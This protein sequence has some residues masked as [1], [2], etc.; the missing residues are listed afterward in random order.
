MATARAWSNAHASASRSTA[1]ARVERR[2]GCVVIRASGGD[3]KEGVSYDVPYDVVNGGSEDGYELRVYGAY[4]VAA[5]PYENREEGL[6][7]LMEYMEGGNAERA[8]YP[9]TQPLTTRYFEGGKTMELALLGR[10]AKESIAAP[11][12]ESEVRVI[13]SGAELVAAVGFEGNATP[14]VAEFYRSKL[15]AALKANG[16]AC[17]NEQEF[18]INTFGPLYSLKTRQNELLVKVEV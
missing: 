3:E 18:R 8:M 2:R 10:R 11:N 14:E 17:S 5:T 13:A 16:M 9:P 7:T 6:A 15:V 1:R 12:E 4:Y